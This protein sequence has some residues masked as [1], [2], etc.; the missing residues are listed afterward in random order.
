MTFFN[1]FTNYDTE[2]LLQVARM[3]C[4]E[5]GSPDQWHLWNMFYKHIEQRELGAI[6]NYSNADEGRIIEAR[7]IAVPL[8][9]ISRIRGSDRAHGSRNHSV[10]G[11]IGSGQ[12]LV[13]TLSRE[14]RNCRTSFRRSTP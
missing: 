6:L 10:A 5:G 9:S 7:L 1:T 8:F 4:R 11:R 14:A 3:Q 13:R 2:P 12:F